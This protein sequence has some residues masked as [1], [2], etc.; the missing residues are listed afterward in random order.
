MHL[1]NNGAQWLMHV[2]AVSV[3]AQRLVVREQYNVPQL[4]KMPDD[5]L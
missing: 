5:Y 4:D 1:R 2:I 3:A